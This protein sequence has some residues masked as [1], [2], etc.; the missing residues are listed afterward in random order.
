MAAGEIDSP[1][2]VLREVNEG[3]RTNY[4]V[5]RPIAGGVQSGAWLLASGQGGWAV[6]KWSWDLSWGGQIQRAA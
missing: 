6:L 5:V 1:A 2:S 4:S 3:H